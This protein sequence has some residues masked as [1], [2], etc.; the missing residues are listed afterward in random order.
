MPYQAGRRLPS[1][2][3]SK[4]GHLEVLKSPLVIELCHSFEAVEEPREITASMWSEWSRSAEPLTLI[5]AVDGSIQ[6]IQ[7]SSTRKEIAFIKTALLRV[8]QHAI[9]K[10]NKDTPH[11]FA[12]RDILADSAVFH[13]TALPLRN[14]R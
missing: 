8:D 14:I 6:T 5:F 4:L 12:I 10:I 3:A 7:S 2:Q 9:S 11:P 1:E 13:A